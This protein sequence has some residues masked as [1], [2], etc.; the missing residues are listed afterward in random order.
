MLQTEAYFTIMIY[1]HK[2]F[3]AQT[4]AV[5][6]NK[7]FLCFVTDA[8][9]QIIPGRHFEP[10]LLFVRRTNQSGAPVGV[11]LRR[12]YKDFTYNGFTYDIN[13]CDVN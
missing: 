9:G 5:K 6:C 3:I 4:S 12:L 11:T 1:D 13:K 8:P 10:S 2:T 7:T